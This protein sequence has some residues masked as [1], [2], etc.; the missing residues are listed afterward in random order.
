MRE[1]IGSQAKRLGIS[2]ERLFLLRY[3]DPEA[4]RCMKCNFET[5]SSTSRCP[6]CGKEYSS[7]P[8]WGKKISELRAKV[9]KIE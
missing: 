5:T 4:Y 2:P 1:T 7:T 9:K 6:N 8:L 3:I